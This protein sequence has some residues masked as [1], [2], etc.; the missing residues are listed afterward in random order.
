MSSANA[1]KNSQTDKNLVSKETFRG[2]GR[3]IT[4]KFRRKFTIFP[5]E[6]LG[7][8]GTVAVINKTEAMVIW[9]HDH[10]SGFIRFCPISMTITLCCT[11]SLEHGSRVMLW[12]IRRL[13][14]TTRLFATMC[15]Q[16][17]ARSV[18][19]V[20]KKIIEIVLNIKLKAQFWW[21]HMIDH[22]R[23]NYAEMVFKQ[24]WFKSNCTM[25]GIQSTLYQN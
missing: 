13:I 3:R 11:H 9:R 19:W 14:S 17:I 21:E 16:P 7:M 23:D 20:K 25:R 5:K 1:R 10:R 18:R 15:L 24:S 12:N 8:Y 2:N 22:H 4:D 6:L